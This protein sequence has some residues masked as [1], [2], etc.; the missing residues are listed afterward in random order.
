MQAGRVS[1]RSGRGDKRGSVT[2]PCHPVP[3][4]LI[5]TIRSAT[6][7][8]SQLATVDM[9]HRLTM[10]RIYRLLVGRRR[11]RWRVV[12]RSVGN[13][14]VNDMVV[15][16]SGRLTA[17]VT[18]F[19]LPEAQ[20]PTMDVTLCA[21]SY[22]MSWANA[23]VAR[24]RERREKRIM[25]TSGR[26]RRTARLARWGG[27]KGGEVCWHGGEADAVDVG[28]ENEC[29]VCLCLL[30]RWFFRPLHFCPTPGLF[31]NYFCSIIPVEKWAPQGCKMYVGMYDTSSVCSRCSISRVHAFQS[32][33][34]SLRTTKMRSPSSST[35]SSCAPR[36]SSKPCTPR[37]LASTM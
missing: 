36:T 4:D 7:T 14:G 16:V 31:R 1:T 8:P 3:C 21:W 11:I 10:N 15:E 6:C 2:V 22:T 19:W 35:D 28:D 26:G 12:Q 33:L 29:C 17:P 5:E 34:R 27:G 13:V 37:P 30:A 9:T 25:G 24:K 18:T 32:F 20:V 23:G